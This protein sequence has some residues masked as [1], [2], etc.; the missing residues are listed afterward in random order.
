MKQGINVTCLTV[1]TLGQNAPDSIILLLLF[2]SKLG[3]ISLV[4][5]NIVFRF[6]CI[7]QF[8]KQH[9]FHTQT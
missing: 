8:H 7:D 6:N 5:I 2:T 9:Q 3:E 1:A 4:D